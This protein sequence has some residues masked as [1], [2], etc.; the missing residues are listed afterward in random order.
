M[1][2]TPRPPELNGDLAMAENAL[3][4]LND[5][6]DAA[7]DEL[8]S[9]V[10]PTQLRALL[11]IAA[12]APVSLTALAGRLRASTSAASRLCDRLQQAGMIARHPGQPDRRGVLLSLTPAGYQLAAW[13][14]EQRR[15]SLAAI[16][17]G[18]TPAARR[19]L[20]DGLRQLPPAAGP[21]APAPYPAQP[22]PG[23]VPP[24]PVQP[25]PQ[26]AP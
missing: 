18:M 23:P 10:P 15:A 11:A 13:V 6:W 17:A 2:A 21:P 22:P 1:A 3:S 16:L 25:G 12:T 4:A 5:A 14:R 8:G 26:S 20:I 7:I 9:T 24:G 19:A